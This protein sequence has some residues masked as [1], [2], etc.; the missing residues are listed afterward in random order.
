MRVKTDK[1]KNAIISGQQEV[2]ILGS[3][4]SRND[5]RVYLTKPFIWSQ[6]LDGNVMTLVLEDL[7]KE[8]FIVESMLSNEGSQKNDSSSSKLS[9]ARKR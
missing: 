1:I 9:Y 8:K 5:I 3:S 6:F 4:A 2:A 7:E